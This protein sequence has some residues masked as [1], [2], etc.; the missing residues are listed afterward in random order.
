MRGGA[1]SPVSQEVDRAVTVAVAVAMDRHG[2]KPEVVAGATGQR[3]WKMVRI[4]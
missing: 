4:G 1:Y 2:D 3:N